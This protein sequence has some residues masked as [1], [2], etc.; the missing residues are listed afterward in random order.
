M[1]V[2]VVV[3]VVRPV[4]F[5]SPPIYSPAFIPLPRPRRG[6]NPAEKVLEMPRW[7][8]FSIAGSSEREDG[9]RDNGT[10]GETA[11]SS[12]NKHNSSLIVVATRPDLITSP[13]AR[14]REATTDYYH[15]LLPRSHSSSEAAGDFYRFPD[16]PSEKNYRPVK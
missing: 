10:R 11:S 4:N 9:S 8:E 15:G 1:V 13:L 3:V 16:G 6:Y 14:H 7:R 12:G 5:S 2:V